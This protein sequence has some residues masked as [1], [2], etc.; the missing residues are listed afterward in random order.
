MNKH[1]HKNKII[2]FHQW[3]RKA[4]A[5]FASIGINVKICRLSVNMCEQALL[6]LDNIIGMSALFLA[7]NEEEEELDE[8]IIDGLE[9]NVCQNM[10]TNTD[11]YLRKDKNN[12]MKRI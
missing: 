5:V 9:L 12:Y 10:H 4:Y 3:S 6:K 7:F 8:A 2:H 11:I 1:I